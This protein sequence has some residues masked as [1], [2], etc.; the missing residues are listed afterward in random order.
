MCWTMDALA[1][2]EVF[3]DVVFSY[4]FSV[5]LQVVFQRFCQSFQ[6]DLYL[7][8]ITSTNSIFSTSRPGADFMSSQPNRTG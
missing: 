1:G 7:L 8:E 2:V 6:L 5:Q 3:Y 4:T